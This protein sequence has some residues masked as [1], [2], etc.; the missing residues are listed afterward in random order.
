MMRSADVELGDDV[1]EHH[2]DCPAC[3]SRASVAYLRSEASDDEI[4]ERGD[5]MV[6]PVWLTPE[7]LRCPVCALILDQS[8]LGAM[9]LNYVTE[10]D[11]PIEVDISPNFEPDP[12][13][14]PTHG[15]E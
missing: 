7:S 12:D 6:R 4:V 9:S 10:S 5:F 14:F 11:D 3:G 2:L 8:E 13:F 1:E 15:D